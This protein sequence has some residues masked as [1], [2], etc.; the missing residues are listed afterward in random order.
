VISIDWS[1]S[2]EL[3]LATVRPN[4]VMKMNYVVRKW[5][6]TFCLFLFLPSV[7]AAP[8]KKAECEAS[9]AMV[10]LL[11][12]MVTNDDLRDLIKN[13]PKAIEIYESVREEDSDKEFKDLLSDPDAL[14]TLITIPNWSR[15]NDNF[16]QWW[17]NLTNDQVEQ[18]WANK[19]IREALE[20]KFRQP[21]GFHEW[22]MV[23]EAV[24]LKKAGISFNQIQEWRTEIKDINWTI[25][26]SSNLI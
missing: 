23:C 21:G 9:P 12:D 8:A 13:D 25:C 6:L 17:D 10:K 26:R 1:V 11:K 3:S 15:Y 7:F 24:T 16:G 5:T 4:R 20:S 22:C 2:W 18:L 14:K 19:D